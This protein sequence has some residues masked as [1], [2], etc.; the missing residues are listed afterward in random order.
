MTPSESAPTPWRGFVSR[1]TYGT[2][3][4]APVDDSSV[5]RLADEL[6]RQGYFKDPVEAYYQATVDGLRSG[7]SLRFD[8]RQDEGAV[9]DLLTRLLRTLDERRP[10][11][12]PP[13]KSLPVDEWLT[14]QDAPVIGRIPRHPRD[15]QAHLQRRFSAPGTDGQEKRVIVLRLRSGQKVGLRASSWREPSVDLYSKADPEATRKAFRDLTGL[16]VQPA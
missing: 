8:D 1:I 15:V 12:E 4:R 7:E 10:W 6:I 2:D 11:P 9:R 5:I 3:L 13:F 16:D 14:L